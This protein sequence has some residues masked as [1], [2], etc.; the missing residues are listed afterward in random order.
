MGIKVYEKT[1]LSH[2]GDGF[3]LYDYFIVSEQ[4]IDMPQAHYL[5]TYYGERI[6]GIINK[7][8]LM[9]VLL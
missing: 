5:G 6:Y 8:D 7:D 3:P 1:Q 2:V 9:V 4:H